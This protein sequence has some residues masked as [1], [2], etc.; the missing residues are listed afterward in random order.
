MERGCGVFFNLHESVFVNFIRILK[1]EEGVD[2]SA[3][4]QEKPV[5]TESEWSFAYGIAS[6]KLYA[7]GIMRRGLVY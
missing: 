2:I 5:G 7:I 6:G 1:G 4:E 3:Y